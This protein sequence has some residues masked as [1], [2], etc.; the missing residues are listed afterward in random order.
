MLQLQWHC[1]NAKGILIP[2]G[3]VPAWRSLEGPF[4]RCRQPVRSEQSSS[5]SPFFFFTVCR[6]FLR[7]C[8]AKIPVIFLNTIL[9]RLC[10][11]TAFSVSMSLRRVQIGKCQQQKATTEQTAFS[12]KQSTAVSQ[13][14]SL[15]SAFD[16]AS[17]EDE[18]A[19][20]K[21]NS[22][23]WSI[24]EQNQTSSFPKV[25]VL[26]HTIHKHHCSCSEIL[27]GKKK[28][29]YALLSDLNLISE[30]FDGTFRLTS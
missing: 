9:I 3:K 2:C 18:I 27:T 26:N 23:V 5:I 17:S 10:A 21:L 7:H 24:K 13:I 14:Q 12:E 11:Q 4:F 16:F 1:L 29:S 6:L 30:Q 8:H 15:I 25:A 22:N 28:H 20:K 19:S